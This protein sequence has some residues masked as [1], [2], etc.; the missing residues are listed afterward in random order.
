VTVACHILVDWF[1]VVERL[2][3]LL[4]RM[5]LGKVLEVSVLS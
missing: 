2:A 4:F 5:S 1:G 3:R